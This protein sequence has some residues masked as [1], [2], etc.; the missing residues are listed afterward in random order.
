M[1][2]SEWNQLGFIKGQT[3]KRWL[4]QCTGCYLLGS[5]YLIEQ[6]VKVDV[7][8]TASIFLEKDVLAMPI[9]ESIIML[10]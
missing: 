6:T 9:P 4:I 10:Y 5:T 2:K 1:G 3:L 8:N 7:K